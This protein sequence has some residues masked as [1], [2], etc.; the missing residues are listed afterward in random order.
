M[1]MRMMIAIYLYTRKTDTHTR[2]NV[3]F[4]NKEREWL[5]VENANNNNDTRGNVSSVSYL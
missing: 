5:K 1:M 3:C 2:Y 4:K